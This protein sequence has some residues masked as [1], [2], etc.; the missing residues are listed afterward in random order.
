M[1]KN[2]MGM[3]KKSMQGKENGIKLGGDFYKK[4]FSIAL[5]ITLQQLV[6]SSL[7]LVDVFMISSLSQEAIA[8]VGAANKVFFLLNLFLFGMSSGSSILTAQF[9]GAKDIKSIKKVYGLS[10][11]F[12]MSGALVFSLLA[13]VVPQQVMRVFTPDMEVIKEGASYLRIVGINYI[14]TAISFVT[15]FVLRSTNYVKLPLVVTI[16]SIGLNTFLNWVL[17]FGNLGFQ[18]MGV[19]GAAIAT[20][21]ARIFECGLVIT[22]VNVYRLP[23][24]GYPSRIFR[25]SKEMTKK[26]IQ[27]AM[28]VVANEILWST[29]V[30]MYSVVFGRMGTDAMA[31]ITV[32]QTI[33]QLS[34]VFLSG[35]G[36]ACAIMLGNSLGSGKSELIYEE[37]KQFIRISFILGAVIGLI[38]MFTAPFIASI[39]NVPESVHYQIVGTLTVYGLFLMFKAVNVVI[40]VGILRSGG[41]TTFCA[42][43]DASGVWLVGVPLAF[44]TGLYLHWD[45]SFVYGATLLEE[46]FKIV[47]GIRR[48]MSKKWVNN[49]VEE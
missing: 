40:I 31:A 18:P 6:V 16:I 37:A 33:E 13:V 35:V 38:L 4:L 43:M 48:T 36:N 25:Y 3:M 27:I 34:F 21:I 22:L 8:G 39:Y 5:P 42:I 45:L 15:Y 46:V 44:I 23:P 11:T 47:F 2:I 41:D 30:T 24:S 10:L 29:G 49:L 17:I 1:K 12:A 32:S 19:Q 14:F 7:N 26:F 28:P 9:W 20:T